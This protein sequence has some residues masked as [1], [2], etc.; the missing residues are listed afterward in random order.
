MSSLITHFWCGKRRSPLTCK[1]KMLKVVPSCVNFDTVPVTS[2][3]SFMSWICAEKN[4]PKNKMSQWVDAPNTC[5][6]NCHAEATNVVLLPDGKSCHLTQCS[7]TL[8]PILPCTFY[9]CTITT[10]HRHTYTSHS[11]MQGY[12][13][14]NVAAIS[15]SNI[16]SLQWLKTLHHSNF[17]PTFQFPDASSTQQ[18]TSS[19]SSLWS[20][21]SLLNSMS[22]SRWWRHPEWYPFFLGHMKKI[23][24][25]GQ[26][27]GLS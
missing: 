10:Q 20:M 21:S 8:A 6:A 4:T 9:G 18:P 17:R 19:S 26:H 2:A 7:L 27:V 24:R 15:A 14:Q 16:Y 13:K 12:Q 22:W 25:L 1:P 23:K 3:K 5:K 11:L